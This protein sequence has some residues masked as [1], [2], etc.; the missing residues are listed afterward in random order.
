MSDRDE[1]EVDAEGNL[2][3]PSSGELKPD[4]DEFG[5]DDPAALERERRRRE[6]EMRRKGGRAKKEKKGITGGFRK[7]RKRKPDPET[8]P[9]TPERTESPPPTAE[10][11]VAAAADAASAADAAP[12]RRRSRRDRVSR[13]GEPGAAAPPRARRAGNY[14]R[15]RFAALALALVGILLV[16]FL[17]AF[18][19][20]FAG[21]GEGGEPVSVDIPEGASAGEIADILDEAGVVSSARLFE[22][23]LQLAGKTDDVQAD[24]Y[25]LASGMSYGA[26]IDRLTGADPGGGA[27]TVTIPE[28]LDRQQIA[29][30]V[31]PE[32][33]SSDEYL[34]LTETA[35]KGF[36][37]AQYG[38]KT[39]NLEGFLFPATYDLGPNGGSQELVNQQLQA[40]RDNIARV[41]MSYAKKKNLTVYD[42][43]IIASMVDKEVQ[44]P[45]ERDD[46]AAVIYNRL[47]AGQVLGIDATT[48]YETQNYT[49]QLTDEALKEDTPYNTR[50]NAGLTPT[51]IGNPGLAA[52]KA[53]ARPANVNYL[54]FVVKPGTC[55][56][57]NF[58]A[59]EAEFEK[60]RAEYQAALQAQGDSPTEC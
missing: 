38:A 10:R 21:D 37:T 8:P 55:G 58:A 20:P 15:R 4:T 34:K 47:S 44:I 57:H 1:W 2:T 33:V 59:T 7:Q 40:F 36:D 45:Q 26:A 12:S 42:V 6:R 9:P 31:L 56:E 13:G 52:I 16:W 39:D 53:A 19:Q 46:V 48:R 28:G 29:A 23:R 50:T 3:P 60:F 41:D 11:P 51:P 22:W 17:V 49:E 43:L 18:F 24:S 14:R 5:R 25:A 30:D 54:Y 27:T 32:G 35:P